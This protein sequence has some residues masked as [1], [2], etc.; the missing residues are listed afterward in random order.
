MVRPQASSKFA[1]TDIRLDLDINNHQPGLRASERCTY[2]YIFSL[3]SRHYWYV[4]SRGGA[5]KTDRNT[6][7][8]PHS[9]TRSYATPRP[10]TVQT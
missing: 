4:G 7:S 9:S 1:H 8:L 3:S 10:P 6:R 5:H 2:R